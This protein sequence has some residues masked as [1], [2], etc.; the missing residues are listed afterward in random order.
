MILG[1]FVQ[2]A[3]RR[4]I[5]GMYDQKKRLST[6]KNIHTELNVTIGF[7]GSKETLRKKLKRRE[8]FPT[9]NVKLTVKC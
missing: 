9:Y 7:S 6:L 8:K 4:T 5:A 3:A 1:D 2:G